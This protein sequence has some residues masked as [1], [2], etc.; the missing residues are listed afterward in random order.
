ML[1]FS[2]VDRTDGRWMTVSGVSIVVC[3]LVIAISPA[4]SWGLEE[5]PLFLHESGFSLLGRDFVDEAHFFVIAIGG[6]GYYNA[7]PGPGLAVLPGVAVAGL[8]GAMTARPAARAVKLWIL[9]TALLS[10][11]AATLATWQVE[12]LG[13]RAWLGASAIAALLSAGRIVTDRFEAG[14]RS[15]PHPGL[16]AVSLSLALVGFYWRSSLELDY[17][18]S[19]GAYL[20][21]I[22]LLCG[23]LAASGTLAFDSI[24]RA[25]KS[26]T[27]T[28]FAIA[29]GVAVLSMFGV[30]AR[31]STLGFVV[32]LP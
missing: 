13:I 20:M 21:A 9:W 6:D 26:P 17:P 8:G 4:A 2:D 24:S 22:L 30:L 32:V 3:G 1:G 31:V 29:I 11:T 28:A 23:S 12:G 7:F 16:A 10:L 5:A 18:F 25:P 19:S 14:I 15:R 27:Q